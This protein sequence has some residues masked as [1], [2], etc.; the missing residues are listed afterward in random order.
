MFTCERSS[1]G[2]SFSISVMSDRGLPASFRHKRLGKQR[3][4]SP[5]GNLSGPWMVVWVGHS[6][7]MPLTLILILAVDEQNVCSTVEERRFSAAITTW[8]EQALQ[9]CVKG[10]PQNSPASAAEGPQRKC[11]D[12]RPRLSSG[13][14]S[15]GRYK[16]PQGPMKIA[17]QFTG[18]NAQHQTPTASRRDAVFK[19]S[20]SLLPCYSHLGVRSSQLNSDNKFHKCNSL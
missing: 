6:C 9:A 3:R 10:A 18:G 12:S 20:S 5:R 19:S 2:G 8:V 15:S 17:R 4:P 1:Q 7:P 14:A 13:P 11:G 16:V